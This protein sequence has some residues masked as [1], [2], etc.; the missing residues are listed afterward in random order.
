MFK[1]SLVV[2]IT[3]ALSGC[4][5]KEIGYPSSISDKFPS[6]MKEEIIAVD[7]IVKD[8][9]TCNKEQG[10]NILKLHISNKKYKLRAIY[11][12]KKEF[13]IRFDGKNKSYT[14]KCTDRHM[15]VWVNRL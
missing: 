10:F 3:I 12:L 1:N 5:N 13:L 14:F 15:E 4:M 7:R 2:L 9:E 8:Y 6:Y 11:S